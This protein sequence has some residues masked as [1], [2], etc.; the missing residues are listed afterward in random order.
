MIAS[1]AS[2]PLTLMILALP[3]G[4]IVLLKKLKKNNK[5]DKMT[6]RYGTLYTNI[7]IH[8]K[9]SILPL[10]NMTFFFSRRIVV[11][12]V[13]IILS[14]T[15]IFQIFTI[16]ISSLLLI[17]Y[18]MGSKPFDHKFF[19]RQEIMNEFFIY[20]TSYF[21]MCFTDFI[22]DPIF[23]YTRIGST[24]FYSLCFIIALNMSMIFFQVVQGFRYNHKM[25][26]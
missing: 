9:I 2:I 5:L 3:I 21:L 18:Y 11:A 4:T 17:T 6:E 25:K 12:I 16:N 19:S 22:S 23:R 8:T 15:I 20:L 14:S 1:I 13:T 24:Y 7:N 26:K 10:W